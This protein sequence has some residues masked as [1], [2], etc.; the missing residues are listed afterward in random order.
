MFK[1]VIIIKKVTTYKGLEYKVRKH[2]KNKRPVYRLKRVSN[3]P[4]GI[5]K[6]FLLIKISKE[7]SDNDIDN[8][9]VVGTKNNE[10]YIVKEFKFSNVIT[11]NDLQRGTKYR[12]YKLLIDET[13]NYREINKDFYHNIYCGY[14]VDYKIKALPKLDI[15]I[16]NEIYDKVSATIDFLCCLIGLEQKSK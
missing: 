12:N 7:L 14:I 4:I 2:I 9:I 10:Q 5:G 16:D 8:I 1:E 15:D 3:V 13:A 6:T 11:I